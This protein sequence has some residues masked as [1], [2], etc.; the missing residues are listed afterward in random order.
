[1]PSDMEDLY[2]RPGDGPNGRNPDFCQIGKT[3]GSMHVTGS[4]G[5]CTKCG[6]PSLVE[7]SY[8]QT[9]RKL[10]K[11][12]QPVDDLVRELF[13]DAPTPYMRK[14]WSDAVGAVIDLDHMVEAQ[15]KGQEAKTHV[16]TSL[17]EDGE[18]WGVKT[19]RDMKDMPS[20]GPPPTNGM[21][22]VSKGFIFL[23][24]D[25]S[26]VPQTPHCIHFGAMC[27]VGPG[28]WRQV[29][30]NCGCGAWDPEEKV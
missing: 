25:S 22:S 26:N 23:K 24:A 28:M 14:F 10:A 9:L 15:L 13:D 7:T 12:I 18:E 1:M 29:S 6:Q 19:I 30:G 2:E 27:N 17:R 8:V 20:R 16:I 4:D 3:V 21:D 11:A 5:N